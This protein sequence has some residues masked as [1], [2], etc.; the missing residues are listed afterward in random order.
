MTLVGVRSSVIVENNFLQ[1]R[2]YISQPRAYHTGL[3]LVKLL[4]I[5]HRNRFCFCL[6]CTTFVSPIMRNTLPIFL[7]LTSWLGLAQ[8]AEEPFSYPASL[9][10]ARSTY[11][12]SPATPVMLGNTAVVLEQTLLTDIASITGATVKRE[13]QGDDART[14]ACVQARNATGPIKLWFIATSE[15]EVTEVQMMPGT[16]APGSQCGTLSSHFEPVFVSRLAVG[17]TLSEIVR[18][19]GPVS[20]SSSDGWTYWVSRVHYVYAGTAYT[21]YV[22]LGAQTDQ[23]AVVQKVFTSQLTQ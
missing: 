1:F 19:I 6:L 8:A 15:E 4:R 17:Q 2:H 23:K 16:F 20:Y 18:D 11:T 14:L 10:L 9:L 7:A 3:R 12:V 5:L 13:G 22:W 21:Q